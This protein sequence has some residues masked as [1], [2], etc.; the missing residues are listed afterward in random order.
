MTTLN[1]HHPL[2]H[3]EDGLLYVQ[4]DHDHIRNLFNKF[5]CV[6]CWSALP[7]PAVQKHTR[8]LSAP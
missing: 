2:S 8:T 3:Y 4:E 6:R 5:R 1:L 7:W